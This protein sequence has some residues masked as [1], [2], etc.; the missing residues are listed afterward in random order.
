MAA[1]G[2]LQKPT[3]SAYNSLP[4]LRTS[5]SELEGTEC[6]S[7][8]QGRDAG[9]PNFLRWTGRGRGKG[10]GLPGAPFWDDDSPQRRHSHP[11]GPAG[12][13]HFGNQQVADVNASLPHL[14]SP[15]KHIMVL[16]SRKSLDDLLPDM[17]EAVWWIWNCKGE[18]PHR[19]WWRCTSGYLKLASVTAQFIGKGNWMYG[20]NFQMQIVLSTI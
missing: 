15:W 12:R 1:P 6:L 14:Y 3:L 7:Q 9:G 5:G 20:V 10:L 8:G 11:S 17:K 13:S 2:W 16:S 4:S 19:I 18:M